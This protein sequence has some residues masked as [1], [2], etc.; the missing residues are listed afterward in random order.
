M[1]QLS[2]CHTKSILVKPPQQRW[3]WGT[4]EKKTVVW[5][6]PGS[7][8]GENKRRRGREGD[9]EEYAA[10]LL[11]SS[12]DRSAARVVEWLSIAESNDVSDGSLKDL[13]HTLLELGRTFHVFQS[14]HFSS[15]SHTVL[16]GKRAGCWGTKIGLKTDKKIRSLGVVV[17]DF[18]TPLELCIHKRLGSS[19]THADEENVCSGIAERPQTIKIFLTC[20]SWKNKR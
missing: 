15:S 17:L 1:R 12:V 18:R 7:M 10:L 20:I 14:A 4:H 5:R 19:D 3:I 13:W 9:S 11:L 6:G 16:T 8:D 2:N